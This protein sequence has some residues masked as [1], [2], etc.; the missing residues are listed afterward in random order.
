MRNGKPAA[1]WQANAAAT[2]PR[3]QGD[4]GKDD[5]VAMDPSDKVMF[6]RNFRSFKGKFVV[7]RRIGGS[8]GG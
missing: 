2:D 4:T 6:Y 8:L 1:N 3:H 7:I 5:V